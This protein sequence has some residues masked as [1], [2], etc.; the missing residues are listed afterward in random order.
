M[1]TVFCPYCDKEVEINHDDGFGYKDD[2][3]LEMECDH[4]DKKFMMHV[5]MSFDYEG[6]KAD[7][8]N[9]GEHD[10]EQIHG[11]PKEHFI[12]RQKCSMCDKER[13][14]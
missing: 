8:L 9:G 4:C 11:W 5:S 12:G 13:K 14:I 1:D 3:F 6:S 7:C 2:E 10:W